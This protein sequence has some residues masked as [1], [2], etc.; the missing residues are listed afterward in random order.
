MR[1]LTRLTT[2]G[3]LGGVLQDNA[4]A[5]G[6]LRSLFSDFEL[7]GTFAGGQYVLRKDFIEK[8]PETTKIFTTGVA[9]AIEWE[10]TTPRDEVIARFTNIINK[11]QRSEST[12][13]LKYWKSVGVPSK[14]AISDQDFTRWSAWLNDTGIVSGGITPSKYYT[15]DFNGLLNGAAS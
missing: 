11:R 4:V 5:T 1:S 8:N 12:A 2:A 3:V 13:A 9:K 15:N 6:G 10:R 14:G 7:F